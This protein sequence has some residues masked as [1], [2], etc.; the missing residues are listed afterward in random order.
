MAYSTDNPKYLLQILKEEKKQIIL[1]ISA[2]F[3]RK[4]VDYEP[5]FDTIAK[6]YPDILFITIHCRDQFDID[7]W[8]DLFTLQSFPTTLM[9]QGGKCIKSHG[10]F[11]KEEELEK[12]IEK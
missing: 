2:E 8:S 6:K 7:E 11:M 9:Y 4:C 12:W 3:C 10:R 1:K 5:I